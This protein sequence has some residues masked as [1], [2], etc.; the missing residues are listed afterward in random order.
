MSGYVAVAS[1][2]PLTTNAEMGGLDMPDIGAGLV[3]PIL[4][5]IWLKTELGPLTS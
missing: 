4:F 2:S 1:Q 3:M 5:A